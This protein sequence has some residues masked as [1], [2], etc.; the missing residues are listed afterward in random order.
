MSFPHHTAFFDRENKEIRPPESG[1]ANFHCSNGQ[2]VYDVMNERL[3]GAKYIPL[4][5]TGLEDSEGTEIFEGHIVELKR[6]YDDDMRV[7]VF[8]H[9]INGRFMHTYKKDRPPKW[10]LDEVEIKHGDN[11]AFVIGHALTDTDLVPDDFDV[12][13]YFE[14]L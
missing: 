14:L 4:A 9:N 10:M 13:E 8:W 7:V 6:G 5:S 12:E 3:C 2:D 1:L 11:D